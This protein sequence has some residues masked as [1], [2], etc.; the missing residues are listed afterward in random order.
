MVM[1]PA[2]GERLK[3]S[4]NA[5]D[6]QIALALFKPTPTGTPLGVASAGDAPGTAVA[7]QNARDAGAPA[8]SGADTAAGTAGHVLV[9]QAS[10]G[11]DGTATV[12]A[13]STTADSSETWLVR[14]T[15]GNGEAGR[16]LYSLRVSY[17]DEPPEQ[18]CAPYSP[19]FTDDGT[20][21][22]QVVDDVTGITAATDTLYLTDVTRMRELY[23]VEATEEVDLAVRAVDAW[24]G[25]DDIGVDG[26]IVSVDADP[27]VQAARAQLDDN[28]CSMSDRRALSAAI[29]SYVAGV[30]ADAG[31]DI[32]SIVVLGGDDVIPFAP[33]AQH[34]EQFNESGHA[35]D[36][37]RGD[38]DCPADVAAGEVDPCAT[39]LSAAAASDYILTDDPYGLADAYQ[40]LGGYLYVPTVALGR[41]VDTPAQIAAQ[42]D[43]YRATAGGL[44]TAD[45][46]LTAG[47]GAWA[48]LPDAV[49]ANLS[50]RL[51]G[52]PSPLEQPWSG[53]DA[54]SRLFPAEG[55]APKIVSLNTHADE[56]NLLPGLDGAEHG[57]SGSDDLITAGDLA[58]EASALAGSLVFMIGCHAGNNLPTS[59]YG[60]VDDWADVFGQSAGFVGN[61]GFGLANSVTTA[62]SERLLA[63]YADWIGVTTESGQVSA[64]EALMYAK[65]SY[66]GQAGQYSGYDE[67]VVM[68]TV[69]YGVPMYGFVNDDDAAK[70]VPIPEIP[71]D[72]AVVDPAEGLA[73]ASLTLT[74]S[75]FRHG[76][77]EGDPDA[78]TEP[79]YLTVGDEQPVAVAGQPALPKVT[80]QV[81]TKVGDKVARGALITGLTS[82]VSGEVVPLIVD[83]GIGVETAGVTTQGVAFPSVFASIANQQTPAGPVSLLVT[84]PASVQAAVNGRGTIE[85]FTSMDVQVLYGDAG[86]PDQ[87]APVITYR[88]MGESPVI[89]AYDPGGGSVT[90]VVLLVQP[91]AEAG[92]EQP[93]STV[94]M[95]LSNGRWLATLPAGI[96]GP[97]RWILQLVDAAGNVTTDS[98]RGRLT[99]AAAV[100]A[101][102]LGDAGTTVEAVV[103]DRVQRTI[104][105]EGV[106]PG[107]AVSATY[108]LRDAEGGVVRDGPV[109]V[110]TG[111]DG[112]TRAVLDL[113]ADS[114][115]AYTVSITACTGGACSDPASF[116]LTVAPANAAPSAS[117]TLT[118]EA[119]TPSST[120]QASATGTD[121]DTGDTVSLR[122]RW[123]VNGVV[124]EGATA[125]SFALD[126]I[127][128]PGD[129][130][131]VE[132]IPNDGRTDGHA[133]VAAIS[134][135][136]DVALP[137][138]ALTA[139]SDGAPYAAGTWARADVAVSFLCT[140]V[141]VECPEP[142]TIATDTASTIVERT[143]T[144]DLGRT[145]TASIEVKLDKTAPSLS[146]IVSPNPVVVGGTA[147][148]V[149]MASDTVS[150]IA[151]QSCSAPAT[152]TA[153][154]RSVTCEATDAAGN[155]ATA[156]AGY[157]VVA[158]SPACRLGSNQ[159]LQPVNADG[160]SVFARIS[161]V[162]VIFRLCD[163]LGRLVTTRGAVTSVTLESQ[164][165]LAKAAVNELPLLLPTIKP[166]YVSNT[167]LWA[168]AI[169]SA[170]LKSGVKY[171]YRVNLADGDSFTFTFGIK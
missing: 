43:R 78:A 87:T 152:A 60:D 148:A 114:T 73:S 95:S 112:V 33:V 3:V 54:T 11:G 10:V 32:R 18:T 170:T 101:P 136:E 105:V 167:G 164:T 107:D 74:P 9:D 125:S 103:G 57:A 35:A 79:V 94:E 153:G 13:G 5:S 106:A 34:T 131:S 61:T 163:D 7:E 168:G 31:A 113:I 20:W 115:G 122:Y 165:A 68:Q 160:S 110:T 70:S 16:Q 42:L 102:S 144:D 6:G 162:P 88:Q 91:E 46:S 129:V 132:A 21:P 81:P 66:I 97:Y 50:W 71:A 157:Q 137:T 25:L 92:G 123:L 62:L 159:V 145:A 80:T 135:G 133:G 141:G 83:A 27:A 140:G 84:T 96:T 116:E 77:A 151:S 26:A 111:A 120:L 158:P 28:P 38:A 72:L 142:V 169:G 147:T 4:T 30:I 22:D 128:Q 47:Y 55:D 121:P 53:D 59:Y 23:G 29:N 51:T 89:T 134:V 104:A 108:A 99:T 69:Y 67:K 36:L 76:P 171:T 65:Q 63:T 93:W 44:L 56:T 52:D 15:S 82:T 19:A 117:V 139:V 58:P 109:H 12:E 24:S 150:G 41:L 40:S 8:E 90:R 155:T 49:T 119:V 156:T 64:G 143:V 14:V 146:P 37:R 100:V 1:P 127:A 130:V 75:F 48:E 2:E 39:P 98:D 149:A 124:Q 138:I 166:V 17:E 85:T 126:G 118:P 154:T 45:T 86:S 161:A